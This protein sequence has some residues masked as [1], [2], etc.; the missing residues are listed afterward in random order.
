MS[1]PN[2]VTVANNTGTEILACVVYHGTGI[3]IA[4]GPFEFDQVLGISNLAAGATSSSGIAQVTWLPDYWVMGF[5]LASDPG[6]K[7]IICSS[8]YTEP[9][10]ECETPENG[11]TNFSVNSSSDVTIFTYESDGSSDGSCDAPAVTLNTFT[12][13]WFALANAV[14]D[15]LDALLDGA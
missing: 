2:T 1:D 14:G 11:S 7:Q 13:I 4:T 12:E 5:V 15:A 3:P 6:S 8:T 9:Y 10:K